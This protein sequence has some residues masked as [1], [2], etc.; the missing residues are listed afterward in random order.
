MTTRTSTVMPQA[1]NTLTREKR[2][3]RTHSLTAARAGS[4][5]R[6]KGIDRMNAKTIIKNCLIVGAAMAILPA[7]AYAQAPEVTNN[8]AKGIGA[9]GA[10]LAIVGGGI[11]IGL[12]GKGAVEGIA[13]QPE[14][15]GKIQ[16]NM[17]LAAAL[18]EGATLF[19]VVV[20]MIVK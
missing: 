15:S 7:A 8:T 10:G 16:L 14:A 17:I 3:N 13:R 4:R 12:V 11:G 5:A 20:G 18:I 1:T 2:A 9:V 19:A 6:L